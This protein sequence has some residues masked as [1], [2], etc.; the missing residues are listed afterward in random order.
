M[1]FVDVE[2]D[3]IT[4]TFISHSDLAVAL[5][6]EPVKHPVFNRSGTLRSAQH[7]K[8]KYDFGPKQHKLGVANGYSFVYIVDSPDEEGFFEYI[9]TLRL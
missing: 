5:V 4:I 7:D 6:P 1:A 8:Y 3:R 9:Q 2:Y